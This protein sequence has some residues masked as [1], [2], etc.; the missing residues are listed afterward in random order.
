[1]SFAAGWPGT[2]TINKN[3]QYNTAWMMW[4]QLRPNARKNKIKRLFKNNERIK[5]I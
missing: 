4:L 5:F 2:N 3:T 1:M